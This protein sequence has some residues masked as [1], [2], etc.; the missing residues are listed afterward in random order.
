MPVIT[1]KEM[2]DI[3]NNIKDGKDPLAGLHQQIMQATVSAPPPKTR[4][5][6]YVD[7]KLEAG[8]NNEW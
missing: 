5:E 4:R 6:R 1:A 7:K 2:E 8:S 3:L